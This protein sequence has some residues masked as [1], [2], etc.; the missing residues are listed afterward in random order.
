MRPVYTWSLSLSTAE[1]ETHRNRGIHEER[2]PQEQIAVASSTRT[3]QAA[4][5]IDLVRRRVAVGVIPRTCLF[6]RTLH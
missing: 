4:L 5:G 2:S 1:E 6:G 3:S